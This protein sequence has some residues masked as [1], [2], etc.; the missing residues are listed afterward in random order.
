MSQ[1]TVIN[2]K[3]T[4]YLTVRFLNKNGEL[5]A[6]TSATWQVHDV[7]K[8]EVMQK[9]T[10]LTPASEIEIVIDPK[11]NTILSD[12]RVETRRVTIKAIY[13]EEDKINEEYN[14]IVKNL[15]AVE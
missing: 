7:A 10:V 11:V 3:S 9:E 8:N 12:K 15:L 6:P 4:A 13:G 2:E 1:L 14:Y 5:E